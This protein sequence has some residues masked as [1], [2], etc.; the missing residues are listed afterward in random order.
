MREALFH[1]KDE[2]KRVDHLIYVSLKYTRTVDVLK[3]V[4]ERLITCFDCIID[5][6]LK[7]AEED[8]KISMV[9]QAPALKCKEL[10]KLY[11]GDNTIN[12]FIDFYLLLRQL[13]RA[14]FSR[15]SEF[16]RNV[17]MITHLE[18]KEVNVD[19][20]SVT[21]Y[22]KVAKVYLEYINKTFIDGEEEF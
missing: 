12:E 17:T 14:E 7:K 20:D 8:S 22:Y 5:G 16:R 2:L 11:S 3:N 4:I 19:I 13:N 21:E 15:A 9:P 6:L 18:D 1:A 10:Q